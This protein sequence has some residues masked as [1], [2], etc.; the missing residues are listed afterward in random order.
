MLEWAH[1]TALVL[2]PGMDGTGKL[3]GDFA[4]A[5]PPHLDARVVSY[6]AGEVLDYAALEQRVASSLP[7]DGSFVL[8]GES[9]SGPIAL[10]VASRSPAGLV[11]VI[12]VAS[13]A[14]SPRT[15]LRA[16]RFLI[17]PWLFR[18]GP[19]RFVLRRLLLGADAPD[20]T[21]EELRAALSTVAPAVLASRLREIA[22][23]DVTDE[24]RR[25]PVP[26]LYVQG[27]R[28]RLVPARVGDGLRLLRPDLTIATIDAPHL[29]L[30]RA[31]PSA[32]RVVA[33]FVTDRAPR[34]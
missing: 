14:R 12:L 3:L 25:C 30:Q 27:R 23:V 9:F 32:A 21:V 10:R 16:L 31:G 28:D 33:D 17:R 18:V 6:P 7:T 2:L 15:L 19:P 1:V 29:V 20:A 8:L 26:L 24:L 13:F 22:S 34:R 4:R 11:A 5:L